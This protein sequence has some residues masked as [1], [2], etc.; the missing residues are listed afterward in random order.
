MEQVASDQVRPARPRLPNPEELSAR[1]RAWLGDRY[2][3]RALDVESPAVATG[4]QDF[5]TYMVHFSG[6]GL[7]AEWREPLAVRLASHAGRYPDVDREARL[8]GWCAEHGYPAPAV[9]AV[10]P[11]GEVAA[12]PVEVMAR[13]AGETMAAAML[14]PGATSGAMIYHLAGLA[15]DLHALPLPQWASADDASWSVA[16]RHLTLTRYL[17][18]RGDAPELAAALKRV[19]HLAPRLLNAEPVI[20]HGDLHPLN[21][22]VDGDRCGVIDWTESGLGDRHADLSR[23]CLIFEWLAEGL[24]GVGFAGADALGAAFLD[25]Y[26]RRHAVDPDRLALWRPLHLLHGWAMAVGQESGSWGS[27]P[28]GIA[29]APGWRSWMEREFEAAMA[30]LS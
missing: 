7:P 1:L 29:T 24:L 18:S 26:Q 16:S 14:T 15:A 3:C 20:C 11:P 23:T 12:V 13:V 4:G 2:Q 5:A 10:L 19:D 25:A 9:L 6:H 17:T 22:L 30:A 8:Q 27:N 28:G 21:V